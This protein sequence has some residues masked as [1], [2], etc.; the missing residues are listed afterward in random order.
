MIVLILIVHG[1][2]SVLIGFG[3]Y[4]MFS[5]HMRVSQRKNLQGV[6]A[7]LLGLVLMALGITWLWT[8]LSSSLWDYR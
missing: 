7:R 4:T 5:G 3:A 8:I 1:P 6:P 2:A